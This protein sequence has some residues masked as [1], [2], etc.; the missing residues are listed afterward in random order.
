MENVDAPPLSTPQ[1][2]DADPDRTSAASSNESSCEEYPP[3]ESPTALETPHRIL[4]LIQ[5]QRCSRPL[6]TPLRLPCGNTI[7]RSCLPPLRPRTGITYPVAEG[8]EEGFTCHWAGTNDCVGE[9]CLGDCGVDVVLCN[10]L[11]I[12][13]EELGFPTPESDRLDEADDGGRIVSWTVS[14]ETVDPPSVKNARLYRRGWLC[15]LY[16]LAWEGRFPNN[17]MDVLYEPS[18]DPA[19]EQ[20]CQQD[21]HTRYGQLR[22]R[23]R[24]EVDC[25]VCYSLI[26]DPLTTPCG[27]TFCRKCVAR[28]LD[29][30]D[31]CPVCRRKVGMPTA[32]RS[33]P[34][35]RTIARIIDHFFADQVVSRR[36]ADADDELG[37]DHEKDLPLFVCTLS[38]PTMPTFLHIFEPRYRLMI[39]RVVENG[40]SKFGMVMYNRRGDPQGDGLGSTMFMQYG[41]VLRVERYELLPDGRELDGYLVARTERV[42][43][44][45]V[46]E[47]ERLEAL[48]TATAAIADPSDANASEPPLNSLSTQEL[49]EVS[50]EFVRTQRLAN[51]PWLHPR[52]MLT[53]GPVPTDAARFAWWFA[54][55]LPVADEE[56][57]LLLSARSVRERLKISA[58]WARELGS[59]DCSRGSS[60]PLRAQP[61]Q[62]PVSSAPSAQ[63]HIPQ[64]LVVGAFF[65][66]FLAQLC[67]NI[68]QLMR[69]GR[70]RRRRRF[71]DW[72]LPQPMPRLNRGQLRGP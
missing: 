4:H 1:S 59:R 67:V 11:G 68:L 50:R 18:K 71:M 33:E 22:D 39:R 8:R 34:L 7:C 37:G 28:I 3:S 19:E 15:G 42:D 38:F 16:L 24:G 6:H 45:S 31:L 52:V 26:L 55:I 36:E 2:A 49:L 48:E 43:D 64:K 51:A 70:Q 60:D 46:A 32:V 54:S 44:V 27:H 30:T 9:H 35:N 20:V 17:A 63:A 14:P 62:D 25:Q 69:G 61:E 41:T 56:N 5:C 40:N 66:I 23:V 65:A 53:Y 58:R 13:Q 12:F 29:H 57:Y 10:L 47:E 21:D 72:H